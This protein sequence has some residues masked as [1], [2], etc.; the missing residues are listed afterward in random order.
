MLLEDTVRDI[1]QADIDRRRRLLEDTR[2]R[3][4]VAQLDSIFEDL[5]ELHLAGGIKV[6]AV[7]IT[8]IERF[9]ATIPQECR[10]EFPLRTTITRVMDNLY[11][12]QDRLL[13]RKDARRVLLQRLDAVFDRDEQELAP[14]G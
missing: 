10:A 9:L 12:I 1:H 3:R 4:P 13:S 8:R 14:T 11:A 7:M 5:E 6:P 2:L